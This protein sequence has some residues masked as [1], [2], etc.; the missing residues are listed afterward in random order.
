MIR[1]VALC[2]L[3]PLLATAQTTRWTEQQANDWYAKQ[4]W[5]VGA[6][7]IPATAINQLEMWQADS[8]DPARIDKELGWAQK[9]GMN[10]MRVFLHDQLWQQDAAGFQKRMDQFLKISKKHGIRPLFVLFDSCWDPFPKLGKQHAPTPGIHNSGWVQGPGA[11]AL[12]DRAQEARLETYVK[13]V[14]GAF[15]KDDRILGWDLWNEPDNTNGSSYGKQEPEGKV[16]RVAELLPKVY[17]WA[18]TA[19]PTQPLTS[20]IWNGNDWS[21]KAQLTSIQKTQLEQSDVISFHNY[22]NPTEFEKRITWLERL[23]RPVIC[24]E[25][26]ARGNGSFFSG[27]LPVGKLHHV[28]MINWG[29]VQGKT[30]TQLPWNSWQ[31]PYTDREPSIWFHE[32]FKTDGSAYIPEE[33]TYLKRITKK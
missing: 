21:E 13:G 12:M 30:Q 3:I 31:K 25:Y 24:T 14:V 23:H 19:A 7:Y 11:T 5:L 28:A 6:N 32:V 29:L 26:M 8:F 2:A 15:A 27:S 10:T 4:P 33:V 9:I 18:R 20:G 22:D 16:A 17:A 1:L